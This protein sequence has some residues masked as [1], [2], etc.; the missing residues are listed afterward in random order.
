MEE[1]PWV[2][3]VVEESRRSSGRNQIRSNGTGI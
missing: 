2:D 3:M 1:N